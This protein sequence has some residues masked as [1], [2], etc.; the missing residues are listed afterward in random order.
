MIIAAACPLSLSVFS[1][2]AGQNP[3]I[4]RAGLA[5]VAVHSTGYSLHP[6]QVVAAILAVMCVLAMW[7]IRERRLDRQHGITRTLNKLAEEILEAVTPADIVRRLNAVLPRLRGMTTVRLY[8]HDT[9]ASALRVVP[10]PQGS[11]T[12]VPSTFATEGA[13]LCFRNRTL[14][15]IPDTRRNAFVQAE[16]GADT[17]RAVMFVP[18]FAHGEPIGVLVLEDNRNV[19]DF[20]E[21]EQAS[22]QHVANQIGA[23]IRLQDQHAVR[24][25]LFRSEKQ[26][27]AGQ[28]MAGVADELRAPL[29]TVRHIAET[30]RRRKQFDADDV[31]ELVLESHRA[32]DIVRRLVALTET[33]LAEPQAV[34]V[35]A[36]VSGI[37]AYRTAECRARGVELRYQLSSRP[38]TVTGSR[39]QLEQV[40]VTLL[41][42][43]ERCSADARPRS[44]MVTTSRLASRVLV[45]IAWQ[46]KSELSGND[47]FQPDRDNR[48]SLSLAV[49]RGIVQNHGGDVRFV[50]TSATQAR[51]DIELPF[52]EA[53]TA[54]PAGMAPQ[55][56]RSRQLTVMVV[57][58]DASAHRDLIRMLSESGDRAVPVGSAEEAIDLVQ[59]M[60]FDVVISAIRLPG[61]SWMELL[62]RVRPHVAEFIVLTGARKPDVAQVLLGSVKVL[63]QPV[64]KSDLDRLL[65]A[66]E[67]RA[68]A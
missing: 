48:G 55:A 64:Q 39:G 23:A 47:P 52:L 35:S 37:L 66:A 53:A 28:L 44:V 14:I 65:A 43:A 50:R 46:N 17:P 15:A 61:L 20:T 24:E 31:D 45:E 32:A 58:P 68:S 6:M 34:D 26:A 41:N 56:T 18:T 13:A 29:E 67:E 11:S 60:R 25:R 7:W 16:S 42:Y 12:P 49:C 36:V 19:H 2:P 51:F 8:L 57:G 54:Q 4:H 27:A 1:V 30:M 59:R 21:E 38:L 33:E 63:Q 3:S 5:L 62:D 10:G 22:A 40:L 9:A